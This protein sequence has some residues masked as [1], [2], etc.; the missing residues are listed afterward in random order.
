MGINRTR[1]GP[2]VVTF[3]PIRIWHVLASFS[4]KNMLP[5]FRIFR[6]D[7]TST[8]RFGNSSFS[9]GLGAGVRPMMV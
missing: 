6:R 1:I 9:R 5:K 8:F 3:L 4:L 2:A 7:Y